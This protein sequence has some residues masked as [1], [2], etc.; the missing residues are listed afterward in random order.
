MERGHPPRRPP[1]TGPGTS[2]TGGT[3]TNSQWWW[4]AYTYQTVETVDDDG[5]INAAG[6][7]T[8]VYLSTANPELAATRGQRCTPTP[9]GV[10]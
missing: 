2:L 9:M 10:K 6:Q 7:H 3:A 5:T 1:P 8:D 4:R